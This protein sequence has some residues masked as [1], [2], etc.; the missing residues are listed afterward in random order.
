MGKREMPTRD[1]LVSYDYAV[2][3]HAG[4]MCD[5]DGHFFIKPCTQAEVD[6]YQSATRRHPEFAEIMPLYMGTLQLEDP[7]HIQLDDSVTGLVTE[8]GALQ[9]A[10]EELV[11]MVQEQVSAAAAAAVAQNGD[12]SQS[13]NLPVPAAWVPTRGKKIKT[14]KSVVLE[15]ASGA[16]KR[17]NILDVKLGVRLWADD[18]P[19]EKKTRFDKISRETTHANLGFRIAGMRV[20]RGSE[21]NA[22]LDDEEYMIYDK[23]YGRLHVN[24]DNVVQEFRKFIFNSTAGI[25]EELGKA[26]CDAF[27]RDLERV[28]AVLSSHETR[29]FSA[30]LLFVFEGDGRALRNAIEKNNASVD[31]L[32]EEQEQRSAKRV[33]SGIV[34]DDDPDS[35]LDLE[36]ELPAIYK[37]KLIDFAHAQWTPGQGPD[38]NI[39]KGVRSLHR[40]F[41]EM[42]S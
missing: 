17:P 30:S 7:E 19:Q 23:D 13:E 38:E 28:E 21:S 4:T 27:V 8:D 18:A 42:A 22:E 35:E 3:G 34:M 29:M 24:D 40:I 37:L 20:F 15:N 39:L 5:P 6:F 32:I 9:A 10:K 16:F 12:A 25:D 36:V 1:K 26:V 14:D 33:D 31:A 41:H 2:A 11:H